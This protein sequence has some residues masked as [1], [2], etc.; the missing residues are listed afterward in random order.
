MYEAHF[1]NQFKIF[2]VLLKTRKLF[3]SKFFR[4]NTLKITV[5]SV[6]YSER[7]RL[8]HRE[9]KLDVYK[10]QHTFRLYNS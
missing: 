1:G 3:F 6:V 7:L 5:V 9:A 4:K 8:N 10:R 2:I